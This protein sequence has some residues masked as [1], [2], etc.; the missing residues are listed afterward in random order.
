MHL[1]CFP[2]RLETIEHTS[3]RS[4][5][6]TKRLIT[7]TIKNTKIF[8]DN[9]SDEPPV[10][11][12]FAVISASDVRNVGCVSRIS[13]S[14]R[15][16]PRLRPLFD[17]AGGQIL[18]APEDCDRARKEAGGKSGR[19]SAGKG[20]WNI[21]SE[22]SRVWWDYVV[23][24]GASTRADVARIKTFSSPFHVK[25]GAPFVAEKPARQATKNCPRGPRWYCFT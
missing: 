24:I 21:I 16:F 25:N 9:C 14:T 18:G 2:R 11:V 5:N 17:F 20:F 13:P 15:W 23:S 19:S 3:A 7:P 6:K 12:K 10:R 8:R 22:A 4:Q 1:L